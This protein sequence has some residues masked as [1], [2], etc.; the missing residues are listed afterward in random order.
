MPFNVRT[1]A[2]SDPTIAHP[3]LVVYAAAGNNRYETEGLTGLTTE[4]TAR[5]FIVAYPDHPRLSLPVLEELATILA[6]VARKWYI[7][8]ACIYLTGQ[9]DGGMTADAID[10]LK[11]PLMSSF[12]SVKAFAEETEAAL[13]RPLFFSIPPDRPLAP[14]WWPRESASPIPP[15]NRDR[16]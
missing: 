15:W 1:P 4:T 11:V 5:G 6:L 9:S 13:R 8:E 16:P 2:N 3:L 14:R 10:F 7:D 12:P